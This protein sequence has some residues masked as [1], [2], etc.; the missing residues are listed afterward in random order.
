MKKYGLIAM[1]VL[2]VAGTVYSMPTK[3]ELAEVGPLV[4]ELMRPL[5]GE[6]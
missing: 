2:S 3:K 1:A 4:D 5:V 6:Y